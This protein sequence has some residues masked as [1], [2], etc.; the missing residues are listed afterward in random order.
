MLYGI[1]LRKEALQR[2]SVTRKRSQMK[3]VG[4]NDKGKRC[5]ETHHR[6]KLS[7]ADVDLILYLHIEGLTFTAIAAK[8]DDG[9]TIS[10]STVRDI[11]RG[12]IRAQYPATF[13]PGKR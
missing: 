2:Y 12:K 11:C 6:A 13:K 10:K 4:F 7:D 9:M 5:G 8:F 3:L 1:R